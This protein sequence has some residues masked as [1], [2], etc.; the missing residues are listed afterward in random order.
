MP[1]PVFG[2]RITHGL[3]HKCSQNFGLGEELNRKLHGMIASEVFEKR[4]F[5]WDKDQSW[6]SAFTRYQDLVKG[7]D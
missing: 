2:M 3:M 7:K 4:E 5:L 1:K 6:V